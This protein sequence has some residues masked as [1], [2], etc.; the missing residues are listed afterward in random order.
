MKFQN[1]KPPWTDVEP[2]IENFFA[3]VLL[4]RGAVQQLRAMETYLKK[5]LHY[6]CFC[7]STMLTSKTI[8]EIIGNILNFLG[9]RIAAINLFQFDRDKPWN[10]LWYCF[11]K[12]WW[13]GCRAC[14]RTTKVLICW[15]S[16]Q[17]WRPMFA[18]KHTRSYF[19]GYTK[20][21]PSWSLWEKIYSKSYTKTFRANF[22]PQKFACFTY[23]EK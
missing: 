7:S 14:K 9:A 23:G 20:K 6:V 16:G 10:Y 11:E 15:K 5:S 12:Q 4:G 18:W 1:V 3:T 19:G 13:W 17:K 21:R 2:P 8:I 22:A